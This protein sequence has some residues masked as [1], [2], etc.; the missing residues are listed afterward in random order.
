MAGATS[1]DLTPSVQESD[2]FRKV[3]CWRDKAVRRILNIEAI[4]T[5]DSVFL[6]THHPVH[7]YRMD[8]QGKQT[9]RAYTQQELLKDFLDPQEEF[10]FVPILGATGV[11][12]S[13]L[14]RWLD[15]QIRNHPSTDANRR[16][17]LVKK[18]GAS[19]R[20]ILRQILDMDELKGE[21][22][23]TYR[24][25]LDDAG[26][27]ISEKEQRRRLLFELGVAVDKYD[28]FAETDDRASLSKKSLRLKK[29][30][31][32]MSEKLPALLGDE[33]FRKDYWLK[34]GGVIEEIHAKA[35]KADA[36]RKRPEF[37]QED[38]PLDLNW[39][40]VSRE[41]PRAADAFRKLKKPEFQEAALR[42]LNHCLGDAIRR[43]LNFTGND[44]FDLMKAV[45]RE[46]AR[47]DIELVL[48]IE[49]IAAVQ[50]LDRQ[51][52][53]SIS[54]SDPDL[55]VMRTAMGCTE[56]YYEGHIK[57][58]V[59][60]RV[61]FRVNLNVT[62]GQDSAEVDIALFAARYLNAVRLGEE[63]L[64]S[65][66]P[67]EMDVVASACS[68]CKFRAACHGAFGEEGGIGLYPFNRASIRAMYD[69]VSGDEFNPR[70]LI[71]KVLRLVLAQYTDELRNG[72]FPSKALRQ[73]FRPHEGSHVDTWLIKKW[74]QQQRDTAEQREAV[75][76]L[77]STTTDGA[78]L[79]DVLYYAFGIKDEVHTPVPP[80]D[81]EA[82][83]EID[84]PPVSPEDETTGNGR[85]E[86]PEE[87]EP[88]ITEREKNLHERE[89]A[90][91]DWRGGSKL[92]QGMVGVFRPL[93]HDAITHRI[94]WD[95]E[96]LD[97]RFF[98]DSTSGAFREV[99]ID[100]TGQ[101]MGQA[102]SARPTRV[103]LELPLEG[104]TSLDVVITLQAL[105]RSSYHGHFRYKGGSED[106]RTAAQC[107]E[108][109]AE[110]I[111]KQLRRPS[112]G[113][114]AWDPVPAAA[115]L[116]AVRAR[117]GGAVMDGDVP[118][119]D[120]VDALFR[121]YTFVLDGRSDKWRKVV[122][123]LQD[124]RESLT[125]ILEAHAWLRKGERARTKIYDLA[126][127]AE[128]LNS[129]ES[130][131]VLQA[132][133]LANRDK[134]LRGEYYPLWEVRR[135]LKTHLNGAVES[136]VRQRKEWV[137]TVQQAFGTA[138][139][140]PSH[141]KE[142]HETLL[143]ARDEAAHN[144]FGLADLE[145]LKDLTKQIIR[146]TPDGG[147]SRESEA[148]SDTR[149]N[150]IAVVASSSALVEQWKQERALGPAI[151][152]LGRNVADDIHLLARYINKA[153]QLLSA[154]D[155]GLKSDIDTFQGDGAGVS[156]VIDAI[157]D[158]L[159]ELTQ[160]LSGLHENCR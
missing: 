68:A 77:W 40:D 157:E 7:M 8:V 150:L 50:G 136:E 141:V 27:D 51:L 120:R 103:T 119:E 6:A 42:V 121:D 109:W 73:Q 65:T 82:D 30:E 20:D 61:R 60:D 54:E 145:T 132:P 66:E 106:L 159:E 110:E 134:E 69:A 117:M 154:A 156:E 21:P 12:K 135:V 123:T 89:K 17:L 144:I 143:N 64:E 59:R 111:L 94:D 22:F 63:Q 126:R 48:L 87:T 32:V 70:R 26:E 10:Q 35:F 55:G 124:H 95:A 72:N 105:L 3:V 36:T 1:I 133:F 98:A 38:L 58:T 13:H 108:V 130:D 16:V 129:L 128:V 99:S 46:L 71:T 83:D 147:G 81:Q 62:H 138:E 37:T 84:D 75:T 80:D 14:V 127:F 43:V 5:S 137:S 96:G 146:R 90:L 25:Q 158:E 24:G 19:L 79:S 91:G 39:G 57:D 107:I 15:I 34:E 112:K 116:L 45:R 56:G 104:Q 151:S 139:N 160:A 113:H 85:G 114:N 118:L 149:A 78:D 28:P 9:K 52:L 23:D 152:A 41:A 76:D 153:R 131:D 11:G 86:E 93:V 125:D 67:N 44:L 148:S 142:I 92:S 74:E 2:S 53:A 115:E 97:K 4:R 29:A 100:F 31:K 140:I 18:A 47:R 33:Y 101:G 102:T 49:D 122:E 155:K 88:E